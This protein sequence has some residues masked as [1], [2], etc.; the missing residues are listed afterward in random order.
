M[1][2]AGRCRRRESP[3]KGHAKRRHNS[4]YRT[5]AATENKGLTWVLHSTGNRPVAHITALQKSPVPWPAAPLVE[6]PLDVFEFF[7]DTLEVLVL[8]E[9]REQ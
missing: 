7:F 1:R 3:S 4:Y 9:E 6:W 2:Q 5:L 8:H